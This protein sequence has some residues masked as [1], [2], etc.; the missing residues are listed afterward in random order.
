[1]AQQEY[2]DL[3]LTI[4]RQAD[5]YVVRVDSP[6][7]ETS[8]PFRMPFTA[9]ELAEI[10]GT[11]LP[12]EV[13]RRL[14]PAAAPAA[15]TDLREVGARLND[16]VFTGDAGVRFAESLALA[17]G[18]GKFLRT[19]LHLQ[20]APDLASLPWEYLYSGKLDRF[21]NLWNWTPVVRYLDSPVPWTPVEVTN[22]LRVLVMVSSPTGVPVLDV[23]REVELL[24]A[25][26]ADLVAAGLLELVVLDRATLPA[27]HHEVY[28]R[29]NVFHFIGHGEFLGDEG[30]RLVLEAEDGSP[31][32]VDGTRLGTL[33]QDAPGM[34]LAVLNACEGARTS[35]RNPFAGVA[36]TLVRQGVPAVVAMQD[37]ISDR[38]AL[39]FAHEFYFALGRGRAVDTA[40]SESRKAIFLSDRSAEW[41]TPV[42]LRSGAAQPFTFTLTPETRLPHREDHWSALYHAAGQAIDAGQHTTALPLLEQLAQEKPDFADVGAILDRVRPLV[43]DRTNVTRV[44]LL[45]R[46]LELPPDDPARTDPPPPPPVTQPVPTPV[47]AGPP[48]VTQPVPPPVD[49]VPP[50]PPPDDAPPA[51]S[52]T[53]LMELDGAG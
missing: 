14:V 31:D 50:P 41:G 2:L 32:L 10:A 35:G 4:A 45:R 27:L 3:D 5:G 33:L 18:E 40:M 6:A 1:M 15:T 11:G 47:D 43:R 42:L 23:D 37:E 39:V 28:E 49:A 22:P 21:L 16:A 29:F 51:P 38:A 36:Q 19:R 30:G 34:Q 24:R 12:G 48:P 8:I 7:G 26:T 9:E 53:R 13:S 52:P 25:T 46:P 44:S 17:R 20:E